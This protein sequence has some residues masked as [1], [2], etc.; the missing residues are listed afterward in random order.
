MTGTAGTSAVTDSYGNVTI[1]FSQSAAPTFANLLTCLSK[2]QSSIAASKLL[3]QTSFTYDTGVT[4]GDAVELDT[5]FAISGGVS[6][7]HVLLNK[8]FTVGGGDIEEDAPDS[9]L[10]VR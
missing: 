5:K 8:Q 6:V 10:V 2:T 7:S 9:V 4:S 3:R 1:T